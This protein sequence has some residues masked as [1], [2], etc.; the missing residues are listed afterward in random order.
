MSESGISKLLSRSGFAL[1]LFALLATT[2]VSISSSAS[3][4]AKSYFVSTSGN[5]SNSGTQGAPFET[6]GKAITTASTG[7]TIEISAETYIENLTIN[8]ALTIRCANA[9]ISAGAVPGTRGTETVIQGEATVSAADVVIDGCKFIRPNVDQLAAAPRLISSAGVSGEI[10]VTNSILDMTL[11]NTASTTACGAGVWG[12]AAWRVYNSDFLRF[13]YGDPTFFPTTTCGYNASTESS[14]SQILN[15]SR[16]LRA[17]NA[18]RVVVRGNRFFNAAHSVFLTGTAANGSEIVGNLFTQLGSGGIFMG[19]FENVLIKG[20]TFA[21]FGGVFIDSGGALI[22][23]NLFS[24]TNWYALYADLTHTNVIMRNN[25]ILGQ[26]PAGSGETFSEKT[27][28]N[29]GSSSIDARSNYWGNRTPESAIR[30]GTGGGEVQSSPVLSFE[31]AVDTSAIGFYPSGSSGDGSIDL[32][33]SHT[34]SFTVATT[35]SISVEGIGGA[36]TTVAF[37]SVPQTGASQI[38]QV[39]LKFTADDVINQNSSVKIRAKLDSNTATNVALEVSAGNILG[40]GDYFVVP[41]SGVS[42]TESQKD[43]ITSIYG[44]SGVTDATSDLTYSLVTS[45]ALAD[46]EQTRE[47]TYTLSD[48]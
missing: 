43:I 33:A 4:S 45:G 10:T 2:L 36:S 41:N 29:F 6:I 44:S 28:F 14:D 47:V 40:I 13:R 27:V 7:D 30:I 26:Y 15:N 5:D 34:V 20:N 21:G 39:R 22:E 1:I 8:K 38:T 12:T 18:Q 35:R 19:G 25:A 48:D 42:L 31:G 23:N 37:G 24:T 32:T 3:A 16:A 11:F 9:G 17:G 46:V